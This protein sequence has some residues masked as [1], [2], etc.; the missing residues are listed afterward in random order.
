M[1]L[2]TLAAITIRFDGHAIRFEPGSVFT[3]T[4]N[5]AQRLLTRAPGKVRR[6]TLPPDPIAL[7]GPIP[8]LQPGWLVVYRDRQGR[9]RGGCDERDAGTVAA[10]Q[11]DGTAWTVRL[12]SGERLP[13]QR[14]LSVGQTDPA[15]TLVAAWTTR[16]HG[17]DGQGRPA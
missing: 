6:I 15:G 5:Q 8:P 16:D 13:L 9:L 12:T 17:A 10:C 2:E 4:E 1:T 7:S 3:V 14:I 11:W